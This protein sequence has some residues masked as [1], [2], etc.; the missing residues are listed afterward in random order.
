MIANESEEG[1]I[2]LSKL[3]SNP[4]NELIYGDSDDLDE[5]FVESIRTKGI[6]VPL[7]V[8]PEGV[9]ISG[10]RRAAAAEHLGLEIVPVTVEKYPDELA[11]REATIAYNRQR[12]KTYSQKM[13]EA[14]ELEE[15]ER[16]RAK[17]R[18]GDRTDLREN[19]PEGEKPEYGRTRDKVASK[20]GIGSGR[21]Y[22]KGRAVW[23]A[24]K[25]GDPVAKHEVARLD[26]DTGSVDGAWRKIRNR[27]K[28]P[29]TDLGSGSGDD[30]DEQVSLD[31]IILSAHRAPNDSVFEKVLDL[32]VE[33]GSVVADVTY[34]HGAFWRQIPHDAYELCATD[35]DPERSPDSEDGVDYR[36]LPYGDGEIDAVVLDPPYAEGFYSPNRDAEESDYWIKERYA[37]ASKGD[38][39]YHEAVLHEYT[40]AAREA[41]RV[42]AEEGVLIVKLQDE[43]SR[44]EQRLTHIEVTN[45]YEQELGYAAE[46]LFVVVRQDTPTV[47]NIK[48]QQRARK[49]H[50]YFMVYE[51]QN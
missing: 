8:T 27:H 51:K 22:E 14:D 44:N 3:K 29:D 31:E 13:R 12:E 5:P 47:S 17:D 9:I 45:T 25:T 49:N 42:L 39:T 37:N 32:H 48:H 10:H 46:D 11:R 19:F 36:N 30:T 38:L 18:Q 28:E 15:I 33:T 6:L 4:R 34:G 35:I 41:Y 2:A 50:S 43:V 21:T 1:A 26:R 23:D 16:Q 24:A 20:I 40:V 7:V